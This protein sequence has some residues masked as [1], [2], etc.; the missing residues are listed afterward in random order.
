ML[1]LYSL[2]RSA[3]KNFIEFKGEGHGSN[4]KLEVYWDNVEAFVNTVAQLAVNPSATPVQSSNK[5][6]VSL[7]TV[8]N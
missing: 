3:D 6:R 1:Q 4:K 5:P 8:V 2:C 7:P